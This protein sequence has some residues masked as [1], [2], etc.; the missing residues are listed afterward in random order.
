MKFSR[1]CQ[2]YCGKDEATHL[3]TQFNP[4]CGSSG[5]RSGHAELCQTSVGTL[6]VSGGEDT[7][8]SSVLTDSCTANCPCL[9]REVFVQG[10]GLLFSK[11]GS[12]LR[13]EQDCWT[14]TL[15]AY[16]LTR[17][18]DG[19]RSSEDSSQL[20]PRTC[21]TVSKIKINHPKPSVA[22]INYRFSLQPASR[23]GFSLAQQSGRQCL[24]FPV[25]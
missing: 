3:W 18:R 11:L 22:L 21:V 16:V 4:E 23:G 7:S 10:N 24:S 2:H 9:R 6:T 1:I 25:R 14:N 8:E 19:D 17:G 15:L 13:E 12:T 20:T 5:S